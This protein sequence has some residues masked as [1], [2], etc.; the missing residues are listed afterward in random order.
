MTVR[1]SWVAGLTVLGLLA[2]GERGQAA[3]I[4]TNPNQLSGNEKV[5]TFQ[6]V[7]PFEILTPAK[8]LGVDFRYA[9]TGGGIQAAFDPGSPREFGPAEG[10]ILN[11]F[12]FGTAGIE[13]TFPLA[14][15]RVG[16]ELRPNPNQGGVLTLSL[17]DGASLVESFTIPNRAPVTSYLFYG[18]ETTQPF[19]RVVLVGPGDGR[20]GLDN[21][22]FERAGVAAIP[23]PSSLALLGTGVVGLGVW[24]WRR[25]RRAA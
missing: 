2:L 1:R 25:K 14:V 8:T 5:V 23:E 22:R 12:M 10:T 13:I 18:F 9:V 17:F 6:G 7:N 20:F 24:R 21:A 16:F 4:L 15:D 11:Q 3:L 19:D